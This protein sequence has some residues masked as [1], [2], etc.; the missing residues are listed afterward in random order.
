MAAESKGI[1]ATATK[2]G[3]YDAVAKLLLSGADVNER[4]ASGTGMTPLHL[5]AA[6]GHTQ[7]VRSPCFC[8]H[9]AGTD[10]RCR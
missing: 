10:I 1:V 2:A 3:D 8:V 5:A 7:I 4:D 6:F 9:G